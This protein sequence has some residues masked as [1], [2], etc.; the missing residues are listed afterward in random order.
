MRDLHPRAK[1]VLL[2][3]WGAW[4]YDETSEA[5]KE[6]MALGHIDYYLMK[7]W[8]SPDEFFHRTISEFIHEWSRTAPSCARRSRSWRSGR[9][10]CTSW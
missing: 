6:A 10:G 2:I 5:I 3:D 1:R 9:R 7:P 4:R 8:R